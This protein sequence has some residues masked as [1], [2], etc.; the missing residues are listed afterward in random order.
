MKIFL[1]LLLIVC[2]DGLHGQNVFLEYQ[3]QNNKDVSVCELI[4][5]DTMSTFSVKSPSQAAISNENFF[6]K[7]Y[8]ENKAY[9]S[10]NFLNVV[11]Y[12]NDTM[13]NMKWVLTNDTLT[14]LG[15]PCLS[16]T[17]D[18]RGRRYTAFYSTS[19]P[20]SEGPWKF[21]GLPGLI[22]CIKSQDNFIEWTATKI[23][24]NY[25]GAFKQSTLSKYKFLSWDQYVEKYK[26]VISKYIKLA[27]SSGRVA[28]ETSTSIKI[29]A[30]EIFY[31]ELQ[32]GEGIKF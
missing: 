31:P 23:V 17:T 3:V 32:T 19:L 16:A 10:E 6:V 21:G 18:F 20:L 30:V 24:K 26:E 22:L 2:Y 29:D 12:V 14:I 11:F 28:S 7:K 27:R 8:S 5:T 1:F 9:F 25:T 13:N 4:I 15:N